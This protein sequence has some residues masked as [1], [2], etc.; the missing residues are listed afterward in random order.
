MLRRASLEER[1]TQLEP[2]QSA[3]HQIGYAAGN[4]KAGSKKIRLSLMEVPIK[5]KPPEGNT[6]GR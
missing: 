6:R 1:T 2:G 3:Y 4:K 5:A